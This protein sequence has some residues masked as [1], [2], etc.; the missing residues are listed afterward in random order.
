MFNAPS[1]S[2][3]Y[4][5]APPCNLYLCTPGFNRKGQHRYSHFSHLFM[6]Y[7]P[8]ITK[9]L[10]RRKGGGKGGGK[11]GSGT[12]SSGTQIQKNFGGLPS[13]KTSTT[14]Y[15]NGG[16]SVLTIQSGFFSGRTAGG[17]T[18]DSVFGNR[19]VQVIF[20][21]SMSLFA[22]ILFENRKYGSGYPGYPIGVAGYGFPFYF[23]PLAFG[24]GS[25][26]GAHYIHDN[27]VRTL[28]LYLLSLPRVMVINYISP[29]RQS[30]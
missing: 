15:G 14:A 30:R 23:W 7:V 8:G 18:R 27:E 11:S 24:G 16:G 4:L 22:S 25:L 20:S 9:T 3:S 5:I 12:G 2:D 17:G 19:S 6:V 21:H 29:V 26:Y 13:G 10:Y 1:T 28:R